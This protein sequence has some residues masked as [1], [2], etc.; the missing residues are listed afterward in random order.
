MRCVIQMHQCLTRPLREQARSHMGIGRAENFGPNRIP[1]VGASLLANAGC[2]SDASVPDKA[3]SRASSLPHGAL[4]VAEISV[5]TEFH[6]WE[7]ACSRMRCVIQMHQCLTGPLREQARSHMG[8]GRGGDF[9]PNR[10][11]FVGASL[12]ANA[13]FHPDASVPDKAS[14]RASSLPHGALVV[15]KISVQTEFHLWERACSRMRCV[16]Q[17]HQCLTGPLREQARSHMGPW[18][19]RRFRS[20]PNSIC[21]SEPARECGV[22]F[23]CISA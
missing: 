4:A 16:I 1:F 2:H 19:W 13:E 10:I 11:P 22:S 9:G 18:P 12:L 7:R 6:L 14:S 3:S 15:R 20:K 17:M 8:L 23:R 21:G 5:Q